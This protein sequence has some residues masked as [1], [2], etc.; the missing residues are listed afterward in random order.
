MIIINSRIEGTMIKRILLLLIFLSIFT[1]GQADLFAQNGGE[2]SKKD[3]KY[4]T[5]TNRPFREKQNLILTVGQN[6][7]DLQ[8]KDDKI[9]QAGIEYLNRLGGGT[10]HIL[11]GT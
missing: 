8:G 11:P 7:G 4:L 9:I 6:E 10:L 1:T 3:S 5:S 2:Y